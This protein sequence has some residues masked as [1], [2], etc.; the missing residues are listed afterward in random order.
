MKISVEKDFSSTPGG[1]LKSM[2]PDSGEEFRE[3]LLKELKKHVDEKIEILLDGEEG[4]GSS[5]LEEA[6]GGLVR[7]KVFTTPDI[8]ERIVILSPNR[9]NHTYVDEAR[10]YLADAIKTKF[11]VSGT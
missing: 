8:A 1:R 5:F 10:R 4:Y 9:T 7:S 11:G 6:F 2:G 3:R